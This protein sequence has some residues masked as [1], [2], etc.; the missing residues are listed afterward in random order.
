MRV[1]GKQEVRK[2]I[3]DSMDRIQQHEAITAYARLECGVTP[4]EIIF[5]KKALM[6]N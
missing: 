2:A 4:N 5:M 3:Q 1:H 6:R